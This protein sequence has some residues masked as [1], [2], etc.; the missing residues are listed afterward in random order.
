[1]GAEENTR[2]HLSLGN[3]AQPNCNL[4]FSTNSYTGPGSIR[5]PHLSENQH[6]SNAKRDMTGY[7][8]GSKRCLLVND[9]CRVRH[10]VQSER[11]PRTKPASVPG[12]QNATPILQNQQGLRQLALHPPSAIRYTG[13][14]GDVPA[15]FEVKIFVHDPRKNILNIRPLPKRKQQHGRLIQPK[16]GGRDY[17]CTKWRAKR[18]VF[19]SIQ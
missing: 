15:A 4:P 11:S 3:N 8:N 2:V 9:Q 6:S 18:V 16:A 1:M 13:G 19:L 12:D 5:C 10:N 7:N 17:V 14:R